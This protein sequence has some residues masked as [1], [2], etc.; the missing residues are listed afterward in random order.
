[1][2]ARAQKLIVNCESVN[3]LCRIEETFVAMP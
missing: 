1:M 3:G 2:S